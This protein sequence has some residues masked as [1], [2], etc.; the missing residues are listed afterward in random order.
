MLIL[1]GTEMWEAMNSGNLAVIDR[2]LDE[3]IRLEPFYICESWSVLSRHHRMVKILVEQGANKDRMFRTSIYRRY[4]EIAEY[5]LSVGA[6][7]HHN[8][9]FEIRDVSRA[10]N[11]EVAKFLIKN[12][13]DVTIPENEGIIIANRYG[14]KVLVELFLKHGADLNVLPI[15]DQNYFRMKKMYSR[16]RLVYHI[17]WVRKVLIPLYFSP[18][19]FGGFWTKKDLEK[20]LV[21]P[22]LKLK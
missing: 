18:D 16:W 1:P 21:Y 12:G 6:N 10:G 9:G 22:S 3:G 11:L 4:F 20:N 2:F 15:Q 19:R 17:R 5:L 8:Q 7:I 14:H 13:A